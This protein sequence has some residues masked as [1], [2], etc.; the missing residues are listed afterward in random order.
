MAPG[1]EKLLTVAIWCLC[2]RAKTN[3][4]GDVDEEHVSTAKILG[5]GG[6]AILDVMGSVKSKGKRNGGLMIWNK[7]GK[8]FLR[9]H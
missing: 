7:A 6:R 2:G 8:Q 4:E 5:V 3:S 1:M 9:E